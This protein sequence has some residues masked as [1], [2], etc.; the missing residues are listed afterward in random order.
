TPQEAFLRSTPFMGRLIGTSLLVSLV[1]GMGFLL[2]IV[3]GVIAACGLLLTPSAL[4]L[5]D[6]AGGTPAMARSWE[7][8]R[9]F[10]MKIFGALLV[11]F[12]L[13]LIPGIALGALALGSSSDSMSAEAL[14]VGVLIVQSL[15]QILVYPYFYVLT[16][17]LY[18]DLRVRK[19]G[20][21]LERL[22]MSLQQR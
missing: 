13:L 18:Y 5:E 21:D 6:I 7:L 10:R 1:M 11:A 16:T 20:F 12:F 2:F 8:T 14:T 17:V 22:A 4:V 3:P 9:G 15:L 19:E